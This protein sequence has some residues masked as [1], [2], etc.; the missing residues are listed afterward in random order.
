MNDELIKYLEKAIDS[1][2]ISFDIEWHLLT[3]RK[4][5]LSLVLPKAIPM[6]C[7]SI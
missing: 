4:T 6:V 1:P 3:L 7:K 5:S 2:Q